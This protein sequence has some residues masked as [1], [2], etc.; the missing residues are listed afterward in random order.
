MKRAVVAGSESHGIGSGQR[1]AAGTAGPLKPTVRSRLRERGVRIRS[2]P[3]VGGGVTSEG[4]ERL[5][6]AMLL[7]FQHGASAPGQVPGRERQAS[8]GA[9]REPTA[10][11]G[12]GA[13]MTVAANR[14]V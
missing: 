10:I 11:A 9:P 14:A 12:A 13:R 1:S 8:Y 7:I 6:A 5:L 4:T 3:R 2:R